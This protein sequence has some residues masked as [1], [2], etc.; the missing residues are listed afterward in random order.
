MLHSVKAAF[1]PVLYFILK[2]IPE[3]EGSMSLFTEEEAGA[4]PEQTDLKILWV[5][6]LLNSDELF[7]IFMFC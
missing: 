3:S 5:P 6:L 4:Q 7:Y 2:N 1:T